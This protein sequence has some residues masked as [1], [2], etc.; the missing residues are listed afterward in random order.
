MF[1]DENQ[2]P[3]HVALDCHAPD[4][5]IASL[6]I[7]D[8]T[9][10][11]HQDIN[12]CLPLHIA[13]KHNYHSD[14]IL[15]LLSYNPEA[16]LVANDNDELPLH[17]AIVSKSPTIVI[18]SLLSDASIRHICRYNKGCLPFHLALQNGSSSDVMLILLNAYPAAASIPD[19]RGIYPINY[20]LPSCGNPVKHL[21]ELFCLSKPIFHLLLS[22]F[23][24]ASQPCSVRDVYWMLSQGLIESRHVHQLV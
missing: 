20:I 1:Q 22:N 9:A 6:L 7:I 23:Y 16:V 10:S 24:Q 3:L 5:L 2:L 13:I 21:Q 14:V 18:T 15:R 8:P 17:T 11:R 12:G 19:G 4:K